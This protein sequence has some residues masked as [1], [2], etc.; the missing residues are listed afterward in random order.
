MSEHWK[1]LVLR[2]EFAYFENDARPI[3]W[4]LLFYPC[5]LILLAD[6]ILAACAGR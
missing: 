5:L 4:A 1:N 2:A 6:G 3:R